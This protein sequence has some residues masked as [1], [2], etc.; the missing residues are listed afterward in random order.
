MEKEGSLLLL[1]LMYYQKHQ[2]HERDPYYSPLLF[3]PTEQLSVTVPYNDLAIISCEPTRN[4]LN[5]CPAQVPGPRCFACNS[6][7][8]SEV[9]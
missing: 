6:G 8:F 7:P 5:N 1:V 3:L 9:L 2:S 4:T